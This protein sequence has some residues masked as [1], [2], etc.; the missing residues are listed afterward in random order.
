MTWFLVAIEQCLKVSEKPI[1]HKILIFRKS[2]GMHSAWHAFCSACWP[3]SNQLFLE[4]AN[5]ML[6]LKKLW[7]WSLYTTITQL[8]SFATNYLQAVFTSKQETKQLKIRVLW[9]IKFSYISMYKEKRFQYDNFVFD[10]F[11]SSVE[12]PRFYLSLCLSN[13]SLVQ[14]Y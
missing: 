2:C 8:M 10:I 9:L 14:L 13:Q 4:M 6:F 1:Q 7:N 12:C 3:I 11:S 5:T